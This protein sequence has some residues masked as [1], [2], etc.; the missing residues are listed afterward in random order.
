MVVPLPLKRHIKRLLWLMDVA[1]SN[2]KDEGYRIRVCTK[3]LKD[4]LWEAAEVWSQPSLSRDAEPF[5]MS[6]KSQDTHTKKK[7]NT[8]FCA[9]DV[10]VIY[11]E[12]QW[13]LCCTLKKCWGSCAAG[14]LNETNIAIL[15]HVHLWP[16]FLYL[17]QVFH[18]VNPF[19]HLYCT[20]HL[21]EGYIYGCCH[22][23]LAQIQFLW[24]H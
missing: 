16:C 24:W 9:S 14:A 5:I 13:G 1:G 8:V 6:G 3:T 15:G 4:V 11:Q 17:L 22:E 12:V 20:S 18:V 7:E 2:L 10:A 19:C 21:S 23:T